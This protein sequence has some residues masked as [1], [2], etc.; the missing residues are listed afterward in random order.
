MIIAYPIISWPV[1]GWGKD[2]NIH[3]CIQPREECRVW[4]E[5]GKNTFLQTALSHLSITPSIRNT[6]TYQVSSYD[7]RSN[8]HSTS[9]LFN[10]HVLFRHFSRLLPW[11]QINILFFHSSSYIFYYEKNVFQFVWS[12]LI[13]KFVLFIRIEENMCH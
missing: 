12:I 10:S 3:R 4:N 8:N 7:K 9:L 1:A 13:L 5:E 2:W 11:I 6:F